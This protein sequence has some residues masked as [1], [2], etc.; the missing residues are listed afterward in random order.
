[1][2]NRND[3]LNDSQVLSVKIILFSFTK[4]LLRP[5]Q[6]LTINLCSL[7]C[8]NLTK[9]HTTM[10]NIVTFIIILLALVTN[11]QEL[12]YTQVKEEISNYLKIHSKTI[13]NKLE[14][15]GFEIVSFRIL[16]ITPSPEHESIFEDFG[17]SH[18]DY[19][20]KSNTEILKEESG[21]ILTIS[22]EASFSK[23]LDT[24]QI[25]YIK[26]IG[27]KLNEEYKCF[28]NDELYLL[29]D[30]QGFCFSANNIVSNE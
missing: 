6:A 17:L 1:M 7:H 26:L 19:L 15:Q 27:V 11:A 28:E 22:T 16:E 8:A 29:Q 12:K 4:F 14:L 2:E 20:V 13:S 30:L 21:D 9:K 3:I 24:Y 5:I 10:K 23:I 18:T 25:D